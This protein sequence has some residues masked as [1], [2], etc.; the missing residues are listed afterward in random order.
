VDPSR[1]TERRAGRGARRGAAR[2]GCSICQGKGFLVY[3]V[4]PGHPDFGKL[5][6]CRCT[7]ARIAADRARS[8]YDVSN[9]GQLNRMTF[10]SFL[11]EGVN[12][13]MPARISLREATKLCQDFARVPKVGWSW[14]AA[15]AAARRHLAAAIANFRI[16]L[17]QSAV[18]VVVPDLLDHLRATYAPDSTVTYDERLEAIRQAPAPRARRP[19]AH[20]STPWAQEKLFQILNHRYNGRLPTVITMNQRPEDLDPRLASRLRD[21]DLSLVWEILAFDYRGSGPGGV[22]RVIETLS[23]WGCTATRRSTSF[24]VR[25]DLPADHRSNLQTALK[26]ARTF[27]ERPSGWLILTG[28]F[29][30]GK[31]HLA[32]AIA[33]Y[34]FGQGGRRPCSWSCPTCLIICARHSVPRVP[35]RWTRFS[36][37][38][39]RRLC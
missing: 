37:R 17:G 1:E 23:T 2:G 15:T 13:P 21:P 18:F 10:D 5:V 32:S 31:T 4:V 30:C 3:D 20:N 34:Q 25:K 12:L 35:P 8:L 9:L 22:D 39:A 19:G 38:C 24:E 29:G 7:E 36:S 27:A 33:N 6:P 16:S 14:S 11:P 28:I 26:H